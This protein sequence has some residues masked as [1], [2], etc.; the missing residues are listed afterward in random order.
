MVSHMRLTQP[1]W[2]DLKHMLINHKQ[3]NSKVPEME[4]AQPGWAA[5]P[6]YSAYVRWGELGGATGNFSGLLPSVPTRLLASRKQGGLSGMRDQQNYFSC[7]SSSSENM[8]KVSTG[9]KKKNQNQ[10]NHIMFSTVSALEQTGLVYPYSSKSS[11]T[12][13]AV[14]TLWERKSR[15]SG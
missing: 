3:R 5:R 9:G 13:P 14:T 8:Q 11:E 1:K 15:K 2:D 10:T 6:P 7:F 12:L 4:Y